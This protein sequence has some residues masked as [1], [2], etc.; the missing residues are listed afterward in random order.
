LKEGCRLMAERN[1]LQ[2]ESG[3]ALQERWYRSE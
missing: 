3:A 2:L 1:V